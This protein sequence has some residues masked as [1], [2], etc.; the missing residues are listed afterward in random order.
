MGLNA[1][2][3]HPE[4][5]VCGQVTQYLYQQVFSFLKWGEYQD[6]IKSLGY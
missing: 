4:S 6:H 3:E 1:N 2:P 5:H